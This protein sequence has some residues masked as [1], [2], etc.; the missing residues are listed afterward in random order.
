MPSLDADYLLGIYIK[1]H[2]LKP[3]FHC[4]AKPFAL[5]TFASPNAN[6]PTCWYLLRWVAQIFLV[7]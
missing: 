6:I 2:G 7:T 3:I 4:D 5:G 1:F